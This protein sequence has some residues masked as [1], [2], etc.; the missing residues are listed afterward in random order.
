MLQRKNIHRSAP[1]LLLTTPGAPPTLRGSH[2]PPTAWRTWEWPENVRSEQNPL[3]WS[4]ELVKSESRSRASARLPEKLK[5][6]RPGFGKRRWSDGRYIVSKPNLVKYSTIR[7]D[8]VWWQNQ[9]VEHRFGTWLKADC[10]EWGCHR[11]LT[12]P[13]LSLWVSGLELPA[14]WPWANHLTSVTLWGLFITKMQI[15]IESN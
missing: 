6:R 15:I 9:E 12:G 10:W 14:M 8:G 2:N 7:Q 11:D 1:S 5:S 3:C 4:Y 13:E